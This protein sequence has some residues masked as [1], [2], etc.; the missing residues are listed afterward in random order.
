MVDDLMKKTTQ[1]LLLSSCLVALAGAANAAPP[2]YSWQGF[3][4]G[5]NVGVA[6]QNSTCSQVDPTT[7]G[8]YGCSGYY[9]DASSS[10]AASGATLGGETGYDFQH[11]SFVYGVVGDWTWTNLHSSNSNMATGS[12]FIAKTDWLASFRGRMGVALDDTLI[13]LT[14][15]LALGHIADNEQYIFGSF[16]QHSYG[17][18][19]GIRVGWVAGLGL[20]HKI[21]ANWSVKGEFLYYDLGAKTGELTCDASCSSPGYY[22]YASQF[23][24]EIMQAKLGFDYRW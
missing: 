5:G 16:D 9:G 12:D 21:N 7:Y 10:T 2:M 24:N 15:G 6:R 13:Y 3:Y 23:T 20:E 18:F 14:G 4:V 22:H 19:N 1:K 17:Q 11:R 8:Y